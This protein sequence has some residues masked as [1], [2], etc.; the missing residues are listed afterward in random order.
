MGGEIGYQVV[1]RVLADEYVWEEAPVPGQPG[2]TEWREVR[3]IKEVD[4]LGIGLVPTTDPFT[5]LP[6]VLL[7]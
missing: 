4:L 3:V 7:G 1:M 2:V 5:S 6:P